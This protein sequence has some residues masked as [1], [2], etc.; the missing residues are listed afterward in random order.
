MHNPHSSACPCDGSVKQ[1]DVNKRSSQLNAFKLIAWA[2]NEIIR[3]IIKP[4]NIKKEIKINIISSENNNNVERI[5]A[6][7]K[8][9]QLATAR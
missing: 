3:I 5:W 8:L 6:Y 9:Q 1:V 2:T 4:I 7:L